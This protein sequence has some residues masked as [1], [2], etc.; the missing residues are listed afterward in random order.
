MTTDDRSVQDQ[1]A[2]LRAQVEAQAH[3]LERL[4]REPPAT[5]PVLP[6]RQLLRGLAGLGALGAAGLA[7]ARPAAAADGDPLVLGGTSSASS[8]TGLEVTGETATALELRAGGG[9]LQLGESAGALI[10][11]LAGADRPGMRLSSLNTVTIVADTSSET[12]PAILAGTRGGPAVTALNESDGPQLHL[13]PYDGVPSWGPPAGGERAVGQIKLDAAGDLWV[14]VASGTPGT[15][16]RLLREDTAPGRVVPLAPTRVLD[17]RQAGGRPPGGPAV[18]GQVAGPLHDGQAVTLDLTGNAGIPAA[19]SAVVGN[20]TVTSPTAVGFL[21]AAPG[22]AATETSALNWTAGATVANAFTT[23]VN[24]AGLTITGH[25]P[26]TY[27]LI[28]DVTA[29]IT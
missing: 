23:S 11:G 20:L 8:T 21:Q 22:G 29:Y 17:T 5:G 10:H 3:E 12:D 2:A 16:T 24:A 13:H 27:H 4:R 1:L 18:P 7:T 28:V 15:W 9:I 26:G 25:T 6:R 19:A 14:C